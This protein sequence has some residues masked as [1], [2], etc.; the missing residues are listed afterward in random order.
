MPRADERGAPAGVSGAQ[1]LLRGLPSVDAVLTA[2]DG[3][4]AVAALPHARRAEAV[5]ELSLIHI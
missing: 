4:A 5:R 1:T 3:E 2:L